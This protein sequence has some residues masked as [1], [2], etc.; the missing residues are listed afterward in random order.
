[1]EY[2]V[3]WHGKIHEQVTI[4]STSPAEGDYIFVTVLLCAN[5]IGMVYPVSLHDGY[6][7]EIRSFQ[8]CTSCNKRYATETNNQSKDINYNLIKLETQIMITTKS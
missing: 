4:A 3:A 5:T 6:P 8:S 1:M 2:T 7:K